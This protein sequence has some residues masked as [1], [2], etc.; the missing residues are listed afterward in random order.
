M[1]A[2]TPTRRTAL[3]IAAGLA[4]PALASAKPNDS[5]DAELIRACGQ[6]VVAQTRIDALDKVRDT[7]EAEERT[8]PEL[9]ALYAVQHEQLDLP[10][11][12]VPPTNFSRCACPGAGLCRDHTAKCPGREILRW[13]RCGMARLRGGQ[14]LGRECGRMIPTTPEPTFD[15]FLCA[16]RALPPDRRASFNH[17][18]ASVLEGVPVR[19]AAREYLV[20]VGTSADAIERLL[21]H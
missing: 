5:A 13:R 2:T 15:E 10:A 9:S 3:A 20:A 17:L 19:E 1:T 12:A 21:Q 16:V 6:I 7:A 11:V 18:V 8:D 4:M 14:V